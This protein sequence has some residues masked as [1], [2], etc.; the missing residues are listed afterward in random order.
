MNYSVYND[1]NTESI[2]VKAALENSHGEN[3]VKYFD[4]LYREA[5]SGA[6]ME[7]MQGFSKQA[8]SKMRKLGV[9]YSLSV[10]VQQQASLV[11]AYSMIN[12]KY[13]GDIRIPGLRGIGTLPASVVKTAINRWTQSQTNAYAEMLKYAP[14]VTMA[15]EI[16]GFDTASGGS[17]R[18]YLM[19]DG[20]SL[21][22]KL[23]T[24][25]GTEKAKAIANVVD[26]NPI[27]N[28]PNLADKM[29]W[30]EIWNACKRETQDKYRNLT[31]G[32]DQ[33]MKKVGE[34]FTE[35]IRATQVYDSIFSKSPLLKSKNVAIQYLVSFMNEAN[36]TANMVES[37]FR[38]FRKG[39]KLEGAKKIG[40]VVRSTIFTCVLKSL[41]YAM[42][43]DDE[44]ETYIEKYV[45]ALTSNLIGDFTGFN[46]IPVLGDIWSIFQGYD[47]ERPDI[48]IYADVI[49]DIEKYSKL[50]S[51][52]VSDMTPGELDEW[53]RSC[54]A[55][56]WSLIG[57]IA[58]CFGIPVKNITREVKAVFNVVEMC[59]NNVGPT[60]WETFKD[61][62]WQGIADE[63]P[64]VDTEKSTDK[65]YQA[66]IE[67]DQAYLDRL[68]AAYVDPDGN[69]KENSYATA[70]RKGLRANDSRIRTAAEARKDMNT[71]EYLR[72]IEE[73]VAEGYFS[74]DDVVAAVRSEYNSLKGDDVSTQLY[75]AI[76]SGDDETAEDLKGSYTNDKGKFSETSYRNAIRKGLRENE[77]RIQKAAEAKAA[78]DTDTYLK[79][80][81][82]IVD[83]GHFKWKDVS[84][85]VKALEKELEEEEN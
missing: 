53:E 34:R 46:Y 81:E 7:K 84:A 42:R 52:D 70:I 16:G 65:L 20:K 12:K 13:F 14:G 28:V 67:N 27:A 4:S 43:D 56:G 8:L 73:I 40:A 71:E 57:S 82:E 41:V 64:G 48:A 44:D 69:F 59:G 25:T 50:N 63:L 2:S 79:I 11:R 62:A 37:A 58:G 26:D 35:V 54:T 78:G 47:V 22:Q 6:V 75:N 38:D 39:K 72:I 24:G 30:I 68:K 10:V 49:K 85:A 77:P 80:V 29:A 19:D 60:T 74:E 32:S 5:N 83:E 21:K 51:Q 17:I 1:A 9:A 76:V 31:V 61:A 66:I 15:K 18:T 3:A 33:F 55:A 45:Q 36:T 23:K